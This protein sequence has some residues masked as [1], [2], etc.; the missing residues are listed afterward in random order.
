ML[1]DESHRRRDLLILAAA[2]VIVFILWN[3]PGLDFLLYPFRLFVTFVH[4]A[5]HGLAALLTGGRFIGFEIYG[6]GAGQAITA[7]GSRA[8]ILPAGYLGA[9]LFGAALFYLT[10]RLRHT[11]AISVGLGALLIALSVL[12]GL[13]SVT[14]LLVGIAFGAVLIGLGY[15]A[16]RALNALVLN[17]LAILTGLNAVMDVV[18]LVGNS[19]ASMGSLRNDAAAFSAEVFPLVPA[20]V[21]AL[22]WVVLAAALLGVAAWYGVV[23]G[24]R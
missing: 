1:L 5:G 3:V 14:A 19:S 8:I 10:N 20:A 12:F 13:R 9:A 17:V 22:V 16:N 7:G 6:N 2:I 23:R 4:E 24:R 21:W 11:R 15:K 18:F